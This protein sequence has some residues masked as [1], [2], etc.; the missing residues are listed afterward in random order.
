MDSLIL[1]DI[2]HYAAIAV[3]VAHIVPRL[4]NFLIWF[5]FFWHVLIFFHALSWFLIKQNVPSFFYTFSA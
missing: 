3:V 2:I 1:L 4:A 5:C